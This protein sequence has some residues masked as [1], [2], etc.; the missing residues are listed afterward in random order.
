MSEA[1]KAFTS[2]ASATLAE[3]TGCLFN[4]TSEITSEIPIELN[5]SVLPDSLTKSEQHELHQI[6]TQNSVTLQCVLFSKFSTV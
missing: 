2:T 1:K 3:G 4:N 6:V 5:K